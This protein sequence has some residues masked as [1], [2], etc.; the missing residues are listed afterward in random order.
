MIPTFSVSCLSEDASLVKKLFIKIRPGDFTDVHENF[1]IEDATSLDKEVRVKLWKSHSYG[2]QIR[3]A[4]QES[5][6]TRTPDAD[7]I[8]LGVGVRSPGALVTSAKEV[9]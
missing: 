3:T 7:R 6:H 8:R 4:D 9:M 2:V 5:S 1:I